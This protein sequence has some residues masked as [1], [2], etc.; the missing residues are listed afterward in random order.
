M[1][2]EIVKK[3][4]HIITLED[5]SAIGG[6]GSAILKFSNNIGIHKII[7]IFGIPDFFIPHGDTERLY[8][9]AGI[10]KMSVIKYVQQFL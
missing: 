6:F 8:K 9:E 4:D 5:G 7:K 3:F 1:L 2:T 10:D